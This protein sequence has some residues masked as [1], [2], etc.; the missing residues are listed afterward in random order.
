MPDVP[1]SGEKEVETPAMGGSWRLARGK[2]GT[3]L[4]G[5]WKLPCELVKPINPG[6]KTLSSRVEAAE[7]LLE[8]GADPMV[9][10]KT[11][12]NAF[13]IARLDAKYLSVLIFFRHQGECAR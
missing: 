4:S 8:V 2:V 5:D 9:L 7:A 3:A 6:R 12:K 13:E 1:I 10:T 11:G